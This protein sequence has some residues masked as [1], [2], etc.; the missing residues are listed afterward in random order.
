MHS[1]SS[2]FT[3]GRIDCSVTGLFRLQDI[4]VMNIIVEKTKML[5]GEKKFFF[6]S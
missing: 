1:I 4:N 6:I 2:I 3:G 5:T